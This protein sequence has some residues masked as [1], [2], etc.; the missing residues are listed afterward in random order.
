MYVSDTTIKLKRVREKKK[1]VLRK[2][3]ILHVN[4]E[5]HY[6]EK[7]NVRNANHQNI[8][9]DATSDRKL[10]YSIN[11]RYPISTDSQLRRSDSMEDHVR[12]RAFE[13]G[14]T[15]GAK[16]T[17]PS[18]TLY[19]DASAVRPERR[20]VK[21]ARASGSLVRARPPGRLIATTAAFRFARETPNGYSALK[22]RS[23]RDTLVDLAALRPNVRALST[24]NTIEG[25]LMEIKTPYRIPYVS[26][27]AAL[28]GVSY[29]HQPSL[30]PF[31]CFLPGP[32]QSPSAKSAASSP[33]AIINTRGNVGASSHAAL[34]GTEEPAAPRS[35]NGKNTALMNYETGRKRP[36]PIPGERAGAGLRARARLISQSESKN[37]GAVKWTA[38]CT[39]V[40]YY[41]FS[42]LIFA[43][44]PI[45]P[46][47]P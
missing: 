10:K 43:D 19:L 14:S 38:A 8:R 46:A 29:K 18:L 42:D 4:T 20:S 28:D 22:S 45:L 30:E 11:S 33:R 13:K 23:H 35:P 36:G 9:V 24:G 16:Y 39:R 3:K 37:S 32:P 2:W 31:T 15:R 17:K 25:G 12:L 40:A 21:K 6:S 41:R 7:E 5:I 44:L 27:M 1:S 47:L 34:R 26:Q